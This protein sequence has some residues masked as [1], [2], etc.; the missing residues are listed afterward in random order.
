MTV[1][2]HV[3]KLQASLSLGVFHTSQVAAVSWAPSLMVESLLKTCAS[4]VMISREV[5]L[6]DGDAQRG[7]CDLVNGRSM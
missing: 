5:S 6:R 4:T 1:K 3:C 7:L 2:A